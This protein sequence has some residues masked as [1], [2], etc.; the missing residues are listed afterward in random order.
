[1]RIVLHQPEIAANLGN[2]MRSCACFD[3]PLTV[4]EPLGF[5][6]ATRD[7]RRAAMDYGRSVDLTRHADWPT[8]R[9]ASMGRR[10]L[11]TT[12]GAVQL[13][14][15]AFRPDDDLIFGS[16]SRGVP[17]SVHDDCQGRVVIPIA[18]RSLNLSNA[19]AIALFEALRQTG[20]LP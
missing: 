11:F 16:E 20:R 18:A 2:V 12:K 19:V 4:I 15:F 7:V 13:D 1:M 5:P 14:Q 8:Y 17:D 10:I 6:L 9:A 3:T